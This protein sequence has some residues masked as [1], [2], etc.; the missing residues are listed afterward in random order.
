M[1]KD[2]LNLIVL[3]LREWVVRI[4][5]QSLSRQNLWI[6]KRLEKAFGQ[7][8]TCLKY[9]GE[10]LKGTRTRVGNKKSRS[11]ANCHIFLALKGLLYVKVL[12]CWC[13][14]VVGYTVSILRVI[15]IMARIAELE[16][17]VWVWISSKASKFN[18]SDWKVSKDIGWFQVANEKVVTKGV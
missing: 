17:A 14:V 5:W 10:P 18:N 3:T 15:G 13:N 16:L 7:C 8:K 4:K 12:K 9:N 6:D 2:F 1:Q 11:I